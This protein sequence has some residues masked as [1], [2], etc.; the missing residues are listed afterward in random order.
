VVFHDCILLPLIL[1]E[2]SKI[3]T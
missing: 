3:T 2:N 1:H